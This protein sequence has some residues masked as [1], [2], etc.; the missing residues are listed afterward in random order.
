M[1]AGLTKSGIFKMPPDFCA[2]APTPPRVVISKTSAAAIIVKLPL[3]YC[4][5]PLSGSVYSAAIIPLREKP[6][7]RDAFVKKN[8]IRSDFAPL[9]YFGSGKITDRLRPAI[10]PA[11][12][13][14]TLGSPVRT[15]QAEEGAPNEINC[16]DLAV[17][18]C[19]CI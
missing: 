17:G 3:M 2:N 15:C 6:A 18:S 5:L 8:F 4:F 7:I 10:S 9:S 14:S 12:F 13:V 1:L 16:R 19:C 11:P